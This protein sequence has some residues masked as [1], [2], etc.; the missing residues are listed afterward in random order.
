MTTAVSIPDPVFQSADKLAE[1]LRV[2]RSER[3]RASLDDVAQSARLPP[4][5]SD[6]LPPGWC[7]G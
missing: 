5:V 3:L 1:R 6:H 2:S 7:S 4:S